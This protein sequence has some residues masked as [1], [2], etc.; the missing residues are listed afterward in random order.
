LKISWHEAKASEN[1][2]KH[3]VTFAEAVSALADPLATTLP[4]P[5]HSEGEHR[6]LTFG[7]SSSGRH[8]VVSH[9]EKRDTL[10]IISARPLTRREREIYEKG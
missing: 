8:L 10:R 6:F 7:M 9:A 4:D 3:G 1:E 2:R 5:D